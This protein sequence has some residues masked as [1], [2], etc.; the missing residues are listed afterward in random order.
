[1]EEKKRQKL[2]KPLQGIGN[3]IGFNWFFYVLT[4]VLIGTLAALEYFFPTPG[5]PIYLIAVILLSISFLLSLVI[6][7]YI[8]DLS[9][10]Y[11]LTWMDK[12]PEIRYRAKLVNL[13]AGHDETSAL[14]KQRYPDAQLLVY[15]FHDPAG[16]APEFPAKLALKKFSAY[17]GTVSISTEFVPLMPNTVDAVFLILSV[18]EIKEGEKRIFFLRQLG[19][20]LQQNGQIIVIEQLRDLPNFL[21]YSLGVLH[22][23]SASSWQSTFQD[24]GLCILQKEKITPFVTL[25]RLCKK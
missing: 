20:A 24:A 5:N 8:Y 16:N 17:T 1:M 15:D 7:L 11:R 4:L 19:E 18:R 2:R 12:L 10:L 23:S 14:I 22:F 21:A 6:S 25:Y 9:S 13:H 3:V